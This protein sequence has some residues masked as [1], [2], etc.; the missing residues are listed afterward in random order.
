MN[1]PEPRSVAPVSKCP[2]ARMS[3][4]LPIL[5]NTL[6]FLG[7]TTRL[8]VS[9]YQKY[10]PIYRIR[11]LWLKFTVILGFEAKQFLLDGGEQHLNRHPVFDPVGEQLGSADFALALS[12]DK[13]LALRRIL[14]IAYS[15]EIASPHVP[16]FITSVREVLRGW[17]DGSVQEVFESV[18]LLAFEQ[19]CRVMGR[20]EWREHY[21][22][23]RTVTDMN[24]EVGGRVK[25]LW[26]F[27]WPPYRATRKRVLALV[28]NLVQKRRANA[29]TCS[30]PADIVDTLMS[31]RFPDGR[32]MSDDEIV[33][34]ALY[35][36]A[37]SCSYMG[38][39]VSFM[40]Y[41]ILRD[42]HL[43]ERLKTEADAAFARGITDAPDV[44]NMHLL[45][46]VYFET[47]RFHPVSQ[48]M[49]YVAAEDF[50][51]H[52]A[53]VEKGQLVVLSQLPMLF[54]E[55]PF[56]DPHKYDPARCMEPRNEH[57]KKGAFNPFG[58][59]HRTCAAMG[60]VELMA[61]TMVATLLHE[62]DITMEPR[63]YQ[64]KKTVKPLPAPTSAF[65]MQVR[66]RSTAPSQVDLGVP[67]RE[68]V[69]RAA[70]PGTDLPEVMDA[71]HDGEQ[72]TVTAGEII[73]AQGDVA[74]AFYLIVAGAVEVWRNQGDSPA[75]RQAVLGSGGYFGEIGLLCNTRRTASVRASADGPATLL[76]LSTESFRKI[77][78]E[79][80]MVSS[81]IARVMNKRT[82]ANQIRAF[83][84]E[85]T[86][87][88]LVAALGDFSKETFLPGSEV[89]REGATADRFYLIHSGTAN[90]VRRGG[91]TTVATLGSGEYFGEIGLIHHAPRNATV[92]AC[93]STE[94]LVASCDRETFER[95]IADGGDLALALSR[96][97]SPLV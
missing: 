79:S 32:A 4:G 88:A 97:L 17:K 19:Y 45:R 12:G 73:I 39:L 34:Y 11:V 51:F 95:L 64:L 59:H 16:Q 56:A 90:V 57:R 76:K 54:A 13:H 65:K 81:E 43:H 29:G 46:A 61:M 23:F 74:D 2:F 18:Q 26:M 70:F 14:Q 66:E 82:A 62:K 49:P 25:P 84:R 93:G 63:D 42:P 1:E 53:R 55:D 9:N 85:H 8:L 52:G 22:D 68:E 71:L 38:R 41:E 60:L 5:G 28:W 83:T 15:R 89:I 35:G 72:I 78:S 69:F 36:F 24:M 30:G 21:R 6:D 31:Q 47:L 58:M 96:R 67:V 92:C 27:K 44:A 77:V 10:G 87:E 86:V 7:D 80:D 20:S 3:D 75:T 50:E 91:D 48:G 94:L 40:L 33:C 37:G